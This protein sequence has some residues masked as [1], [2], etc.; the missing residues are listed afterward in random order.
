[1]AKDNIFDAL[2][3]IP[4]GVAGGLNKVAM[5]FHD[6]DYERRT[7]AQEQ[8]S[9]LKAKLEIAR[10]L[11]GI[12]TPAGQQYMTELMGDPE[13]QKFAG[14]FKVPENGFQAQESPDIPFG[15]S[16]EQYAQ[17]NQ[18]KYSTSGED[19]F[20]KISTLLGLQGKNRGEFGDTFHHGVS[21]MISDELDQITGMP[22]KATETPNISLADQLSG[23]PQNQK[24]NWFDDTYSQG[25]IRQKA[26][27]TIAMLVDGGMD[28][29]EARE[30]IA[31]EYED[32]KAK[33]AK[34]IFKQYPDI[35]LDQM[36]TDQD[37]RQQAVS[38]NKTVVDNGD[39]VD[40]TPQTYSDLGID[41]PEVA[42]QFAY[43]EQMVDKDIPELDLKQAVSQKPDFFKELGQY[44]T[45]GVPDGKGGIRK[46]TREEIVR[47]IRLEWRL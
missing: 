14:N 12:K 47:I 3:S 44:V 7:T 34:D 37:S 32:L 24:R 5:A 38:T 1:M 31:T 26:Q 18:S 21:D 27:D 45:N 39:G 13:I 19:Q 25:D 41:S 30:R 33:E 23:L 16:P 36:F 46:L 28:I 9:G 11:G 17:H 42:E 2:L 22:A 10:S 20:D 4:Q 40:T 8:Q 43:L 29:N 15:V 35:D 6:P